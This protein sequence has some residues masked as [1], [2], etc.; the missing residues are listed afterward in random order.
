MIQ[1]YK[2]NKN[3]PFCFDFTSS[4]QTP[5]LGVPNLGVQNLLVSAGMKINCK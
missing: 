2:Y 5:P 4:V 1:Q 3:Y